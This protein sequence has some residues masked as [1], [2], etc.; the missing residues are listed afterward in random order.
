MNSHSSV[1][2]LHIMS[3]KS[4]VRNFVKM[5]KYR[6]ICTLPKFHSYNHPENNRL[7]AVLKS[8]ALLPNIIS[9]IILGGRPNKFSPAV[10]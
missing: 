2:V 3:L 5:R 7:S 9:P 6:F 8:L 10:C 4:C 1:F